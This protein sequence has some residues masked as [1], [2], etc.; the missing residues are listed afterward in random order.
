MVTD[1]M[2][3][4]RNSEKNPRNLWLGLMVLLAF[5]SLEACDK[6]P[7]SEDVRPV[8]TMVIETHMTGDLIT[9]TGQ[10]NARHET[11]LAF[12][13]SG[14]LVERLVTIGDIVKA[15][16]IVAKLDA[17]TERNTRDAA[18]ADYTAAVAFLDQSEAAERRYG[19][20]INEK[21]VSQQ[22]YEEALKQH[23]TARSQVKAAR[24][25]LDSAEDQLGY[26]V[27][28]ADADGVITAKGAEPGEV[29]HVGQMI[30]ALAHEKGRD[31]VF[32]MPAQ[33][34]RDGISVNQEVEVWLVDNPDIKTTGKVRE[35]SPQ[36]DPSTRTYQVKVG[37]DALPSGMFLGSTVV[38]RLK[39]RTGTLI[40]IPSYALAM[41]E[42]KPAVWIIDPKTN[43]VHKREIEITRY[44]RDAAIVASGL[45]S[46][47][48][49][50]TAGV[51]SLF[52]GQKVKLLEGENG[53]P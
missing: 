29:V 17:E 23:K 3:I 18:K 52:E 32:D 10:L 2:A 20:L 22:E 28:K 15:D 39:L 14:K 42:T 46:G 50:V 26:T 34:I 35:I 43:T 36:A 40:E 7:E 31:A 44:T 51:Q 27:L 1:M 8:R 16:Q 45:Q 24:A 11:K 6:Q 13:L 9:L 5:L 37:L 53:R 19:N 30:V 38:G 21:A 12:R 33:I 48:R 47:E 4:V 49:I 41:A 25:K